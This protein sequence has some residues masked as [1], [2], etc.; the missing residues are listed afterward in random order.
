[1]QPT[2]ITRALNELG[3]E[4]ISAH[5]PQAKGRVERFFHTAKIGSSSNCVWLAHDGRGSECLSRSGV[6]A[7]LGTTLHRSP[8]PI[9]PMRTDR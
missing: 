2:Q 4:R 7:G 6:S 1:M 9:V 3:I 5:S 8:E